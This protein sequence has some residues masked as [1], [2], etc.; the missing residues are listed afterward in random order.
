LGIWI[1]SE[2]LTSKVLIGGGFILAGVYLTEHEGDEEK[3]PENS[4]V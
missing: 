3:A 4:A 1:L 2:R